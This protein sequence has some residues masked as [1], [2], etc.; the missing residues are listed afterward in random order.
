MAKRGK[1]KQSDSPA[2]P[3]DD[4]VGALRNLAEYPPFELGRRGNDLVDESDGLTLRRRDDQLFISRS[5]IRLRGPG[6]DQKSLAPSAV[7]EVR[8]YRRYVPHGDYHLWHTEL[9]DHADNRVVIAMTRNA[10]KSWDLATTIARLINVPLAHGKNFHRRIGVTE[11]RQSLWERADEMPLDA[12]TPEP[13]DGCE[14]RE[15]DGAIELSVRDERQSSPVMKEWASFLFGYSFLVGLFSLLG[16]VSLFHGGESH[17]LM[18]AAPPIGAVFFFLMMM[19][20]WK[21]RP[22]PK[23]VKSTVQVTTG[24]QIVWKEQAGGRATHNTYD[25]NQ[26]L[27]LS[28]DPPYLVGVNGERHFA[29]LLDPP[30]RRPIGEWLEK[31]IIYCRAIH[32]GRRRQTLL[33]QTKLDDSVSATDVLKAD[34]VPVKIE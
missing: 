1:A 3:P 30:A 34:P 25:L 12:A 17:G 32:T 24:G 29:T 26:Y 23:V 14:S 15:L 2:P 5:V 13:P 22:R 31:A 18:R 16:Y 20:F 9:A 19:V 28:V 21:E 8:M 33:N 6:G 10:K 7:R 11:F 4:F 27:D